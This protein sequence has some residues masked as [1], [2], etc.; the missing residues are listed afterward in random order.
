MG[1]KGDPE[2]DT[3]KRDDKKRPRGRRE[4]DKPEIH[5]C[6][7]V[8]LQGVIYRSVCALPVDHRSTAEKPHG[9][10]VLSDSYVSVLFIM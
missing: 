6:F 1:E 7:D 8:S 5:C 4:G 3:Q 9:N 2:V 10:V